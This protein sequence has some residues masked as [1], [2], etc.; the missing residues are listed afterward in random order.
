MSERFDWS[1][2]MR[3]GM[4]GLGLSPSDFWALTPFELSLMLGFEGGASPMLRGRLDELSRT[5]PDKSKG[6]IHE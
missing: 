1:A 6:P 2:L 5:F 4:Q 3:A